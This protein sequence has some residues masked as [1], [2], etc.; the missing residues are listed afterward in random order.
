LRIEDLDYPI[1]AGIGAP[2]PP[3]HYR[4]VFIYQGAVRLTWGNG[5]RVLPSRTIILS[6]PGADHRVAAGTGARIGQ[7][8]F[9]KSV[10]DPDVLGRAADLLLQGYGGRERAGEKPPRVFRFPPAMAEE[11]GALMA[12]IEAEGKQKRSGFQSMQ[13]LALMELILVMERSLTE[14][15]DGGSAGSQRFRIEDAVDYIRQRYAEELSLP[16]IAARFGLNPSYLS[17]L[18]ARHTGYHL[19]EFVNRMRIQKSCLLLKRTEM[20]ILEIAFSVGYNNLSHFNRYFRRIAG[21]SPREY[22]KRSR[23]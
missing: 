20:S 21:M 9:C 2:V 19:F 1:T 8:T 6:P 22:R 15:P 13:R 18:F 10:I 12:R 5:E 23:M 4:I 7:A 14:R 3:H 17:R 11:A 16:V